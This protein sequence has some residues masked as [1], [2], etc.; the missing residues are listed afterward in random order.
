M[1][2]ESGLVEECIAALHQAPLGVTFACF[3]SIRKGKN[4][5]IPVPQKGDKFLGNHAVMVFGYSRE[6]RVFYFRN[7]WGKE[8]GD[9]GNGS[10]PFDYFNNRE[11]VPEIICA[12]IT[13]R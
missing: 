1:I 8:W 2:K 12:T 11:W 7:S 3:D 13:P 5:R 9:N 10:L 4:G 6:E